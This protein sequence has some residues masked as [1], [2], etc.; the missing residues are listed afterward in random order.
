MALFEKG[1]IGD[2]EV[3]FLSR[4]NADDWFYLIEQHFFIEDLTEVVDDVLLDRKNSGKTQP[5]ER[6]L[7]EPLSSSKEKAEGSSWKKKNLAIWRTVSYA[8]RCRIPKS[9]FSGDVIS[10]LQ[11]KYVLGTMPLTYTII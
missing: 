4:S 9:A 6:P 11:G 8:D 3:N 10:W 1:R 2:F 5:T 7:E